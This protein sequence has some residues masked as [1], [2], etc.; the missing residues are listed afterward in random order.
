MAFAFLFNFAFV[1]TLLEIH[2]ADFGMSHFFIQLC[3]IFQSAVYFIMSLT[4]GPMLRKLKENNIMF[5]GALSLG[6][7]YILMAPWKLIFPDNVWLVVIS[8]P[9]SSIGQSLTY[10]NQ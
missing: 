6:L 8:L 7:S 1:Q 3:F 10:G 4:A 9:F 5:I 2:L